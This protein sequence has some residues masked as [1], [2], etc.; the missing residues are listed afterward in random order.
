MKINN[1]AT[2]FETVFKDTFTDELVENVIETILK[3]KVDSVPSNLKPEFGIYVFFL[4]QKD[5][6]H[7]F[8]EL[9]EKWNEEGILKTPNAINKNFENNKELNGSYSF[10]VGKSEKLSKRINEHLTHHN[11]HATYGLKLANRKNFNLHDFEIGYWVLPLD[12]TFSKEIKQFIITT[13]EQKVR[14]KLNP[15]IGKK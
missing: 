12:N 5:K 15:L 8:K 11:N 9:E 13:L 14:E 3:N 7:S 4:K 10:Y 2:Q 1:F 6:F